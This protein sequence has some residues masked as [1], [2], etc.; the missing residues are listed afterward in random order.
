MNLRFVLD[1]YTQAYRS[2]ETRLGLWTE[3][4]NTSP[5]IESCE[6]LMQLPYNLHD[7]NK[8]RPIFRMY[9]YFANAAQV[10]GAPDHAK[11][12]GA[13]AR[14]AALQL[15]DVTDEHVAGGMH[16]LGYY[17]HR[18]G[19]MPR[20]RLLNKLVLTACESLSL[21]VGAAL[22][23]H[24]MMTRGLLATDTNERRL[25]MAQMR[26][27]PLEDCRYSTWINSW[28][29]LYIEIHAWRDA[30]CPP[31]GADINV[32][33]RLLLEFQSASQCSISDSTA[34]QLMVMG[35]AAMVRLAAGDNQGALR[36]AN[37]C[38]RGLQVYGSDC[39]G[40]LLILSILMPAAEFCAFIH[41]RLG[42][43][44]MLNED[45][46]FFGYVGARIPICKSAVAHHESVLT[47]LRPDQ[48]SPPGTQAGSLSGS[49]PQPRS[50]PLPARK[51]LAMFTEDVTARQL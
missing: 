37:T 36:L 45:V 42:Q 4:I 49:P 44:R 34:R 14:L 25:I 47:V 48:T 23:R 50:P 12:F 28:L 6:Q 2:S 10:Y 18:A 26:E 46:T 31:G 24:A 33:E 32:L 1:L 20:A 16:F 40:Q 22:R 43:L 27:A 17:F 5:S 21:P 38:I 41:N 9:S 8:I 7:L 19:D 51:P 29:E 13:R 11:E 35:F 15:Y 3:M 30:G 39:A